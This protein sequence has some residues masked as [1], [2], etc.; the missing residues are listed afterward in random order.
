MKGIH[1]LINL[2]C[3]GK[4]AK[5]SSYKDITWIF[6]LFIAFFTLFNSLNKNFDL[7]KAK[8]YAKLCQCV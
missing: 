6:K 7:K 3:F 2:Y 8:L 5:H 1:H 4:Q